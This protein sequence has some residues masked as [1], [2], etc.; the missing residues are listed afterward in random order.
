MNGSN[1]SS[2]YVVNPYMFQPLGSIIATKQ[3]TYNSQKQKVIN[4][5]NESSIHAVNP[6]IS[7]PL[8]SII[9]TKFG[10]TFA[11]MKALTS[12]HSQTSRD[13]NLIEI[14]LDKKVY[15]NHNSN[16]NMYPKISQTTVHQIL[17]KTHIT[18]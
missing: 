1:E 14:L 9:A 2:I 17:H 7:Q 18:K 3:N 16:I 5:S 11:H 8:G 13:I 10:L 4:C 6:Y 12:H 15:K